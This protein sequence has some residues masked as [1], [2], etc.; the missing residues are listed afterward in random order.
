MGGMNADQLVRIMNG[1][2]KAEAHKAQ[3][4]IVS[5]HLDDPAAPT[6]ILM[7]CANGK[8]REYL[9]PA[10]TPTELRLKVWEGFAK[11]LK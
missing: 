4:K 3:W 7:E 2:Y 1:Y 8:T 9:F 10:Q 6:K 5:A 11:G